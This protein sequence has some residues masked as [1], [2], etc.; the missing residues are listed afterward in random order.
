V[1]SEGFS[2]FLIRRVRKAGE[3]SGESGKKWNFSK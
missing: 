1:V 2:Q 3:K